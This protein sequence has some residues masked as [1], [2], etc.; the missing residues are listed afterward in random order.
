M[1]LRIYLK[2]IL[3]YTNE[4]VPLPQLSKYIER[5]W[6]NYACRLL[7]ISIIL[8]VPVCRITVSVSWKVLIAYQYDLH[9][10]FQI[11]TSIYYLFLSNANN[12][13]TNRPFAKN[14]IVLLIRPQN[15]KFHQ[16]L[17]FSKICALPL[18][19]W[20]YFLYNLWIRKSNK[21]VKNA[22]H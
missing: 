14:V 15:I 21:G 8:Y 22:W 2:I 6:R 1:I 9:L 11:R 7:C 4:T 10:D 18:K 12:W 5:Q 20:N 16:K 19:K 3:K 13:H 17:F